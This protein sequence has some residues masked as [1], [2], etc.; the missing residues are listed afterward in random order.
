MV[1][2]VL[3]GLGDGTTVVDGFGDGAAVTVGAFVVA[4]GVEEEGLQPQLLG[5][6]TT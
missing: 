2:E 1:Q 3:V 4:G 5:G 6:V